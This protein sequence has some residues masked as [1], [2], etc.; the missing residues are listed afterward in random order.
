ML[1]ILHRAAGVA[2]GGRSGK[3]AEILL[4]E[5]QGEDRGGGIL[6]EEVLVLEVGDAGHPGAQEQGGPHRAE[7]LSLI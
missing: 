7:P 2:K 6:G 1:L 4:P 5:V 3:R